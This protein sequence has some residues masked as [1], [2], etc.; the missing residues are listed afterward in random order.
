MSLM[1]VLAAVGLACMPAPPTPAAASPILRGL[2]ALWHP[3]I[4]LTLQMLWIASFLYTG[5]SQVT[6]ATIHFHVHRHLT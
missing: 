6:G 2:S 4:L 5:R 1:A 3:A